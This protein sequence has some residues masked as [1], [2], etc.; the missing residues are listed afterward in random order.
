M[1]SYVIVEMF[2]FLLFCLVISLLGFMNY[3]IFCFSIK[4]K[5]L[6]ENIMLIIDFFKLI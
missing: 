5:I 2:F 3:L 1:Y 4:F 6:R